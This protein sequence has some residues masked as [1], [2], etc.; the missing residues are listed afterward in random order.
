MLPTLKEQSTAKGRKKALH[1]LLLSANGAKLS[2]DYNLYIYL[3]D[4]RNFL[5]YI[6]CKLFV[7]KKAF[8]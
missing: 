2:C 6:E 4:N 3:N 7:Y 1:N 8:H 5:F